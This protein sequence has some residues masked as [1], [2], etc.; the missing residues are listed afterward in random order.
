[1]GILGIKKSLFSKKTKKKIVSIVWEAK[2]YL[3]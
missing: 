3:T 1:M 2:L